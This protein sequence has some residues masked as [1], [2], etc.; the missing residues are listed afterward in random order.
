MIDW[1]V[2]QDDTGRDKDTDNNRQDDTGRDKYT[3]NNRQDKRK[4]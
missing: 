4:V 2:R 3:D 1:T